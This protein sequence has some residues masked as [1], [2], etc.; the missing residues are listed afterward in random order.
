VFEE[1]RMPATIISGKDVSAAIREE[2]KV[3]A[4]RLRERG[5]V[6]GLGVI[7]VGEDPASVSY[8]AG[9]AKA[10]EDIGF[11]G[12]TFNLPATA[13]EEDILRV[14][15]ELNRDES[16]HGSWFSCRSRSTSARTRSSTPF[17]PR[18][19]STAFIR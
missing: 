4:R 5:V 11:T 9:K 1:E 18:R 12:R 19:T 13:A 2:L 7:L 16:T 17:A 14:I 10:A 6:P 3:R 15:G 8:V